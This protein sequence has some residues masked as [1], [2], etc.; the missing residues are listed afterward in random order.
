MGLGNSLANTPQR[1]FS[2]QCRA[3]AKAR[4]WL[5][6]MMGLQLSS[7]IAPHQYPY[8]YF[9]PHWLLLLGWLAKT[10]TSQ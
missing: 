1:V 9:T 8:P 3:Q 7:H 5:G 4:A 6:S 10:I 2:N